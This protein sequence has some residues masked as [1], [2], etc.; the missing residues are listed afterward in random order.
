M[1]QRI[2]IC[3]IMIL[4]SIQLLMYQ[5]YRVLQ[6]IAT[7]GCTDLNNMTNILIILKVQVRLLS[8]IA[9]E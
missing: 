4:I 2:A 7:I 6:C 3:K 8:D 9:I 5:Y 1:H